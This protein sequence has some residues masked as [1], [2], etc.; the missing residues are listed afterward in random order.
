MRE[1]EREGK[2]INNLTSA[3]CNWDASL[4]VVSLVCVAVP[5]MIGHRGRGSKKCLTQGGEEGEKQP[6]DPGGR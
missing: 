1:R 4:L 6:P 3:G 2:T 5:V